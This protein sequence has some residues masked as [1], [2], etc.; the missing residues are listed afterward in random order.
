[1]NLN[2]IKG[3]IEIN[4]LSFD[5]KDII[6]ALIEQGIPVELSEDILL[7]GK[8]VISSR[9]DLVSGGY[10]QIAKVCRYYKAPPITKK[11]ID[12][13]SVE[14][15]EN[16]TNLK[17]QY[18][19]DTQQNIYIE[20]IPVDDL[21]SPVGNYSENKFSSSK[22]SPNVARPLLPKGDNRY[23]SPTMRGVSIPSHH[24]IS[25]YGFNHITRS[26]YMEDKSESSYCANCHKK[27][28]REWTF[29]GYCG[30]PLK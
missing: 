3:N 30:Y 10:C 2:K 17:P 24:G 19:I 15:V 26:S 25:S 27:V 5:P 9:T 22:V 23:N 6:N 1:M 12:N 8:K 16:D 18:G 20:E 7:I 14:G 4:N 21:L 13:L 29:C 11:S 28:K